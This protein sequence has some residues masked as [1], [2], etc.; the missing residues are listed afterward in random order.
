MSA[1]ISI[2][3]THRIDA[4]TS[5]LIERLIGAL[6][7]TLVG[8]ETAVTNNTSGPSAAASAQ[9][10]DERTETPARERGKPATG[11]KRR[12]KEEVAEDAAAGA[13]TLAATD[14]AEAAERKDGR[15]AT[16]SGGDPPDEGFDR[17]S[18]DKIREGIRA[19]NKA[20]GPVETKA[21]FDGLTGGSIS[22]IKDNAEY[23]V[24]A[25]RLA[26][27]LAAK[28]AESSAAAPASTGG[29]FD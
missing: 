1:S 6:D 2:E 7:A 15:E 11:K 5:N 24:L 3:I 4:P 12:T 21:L 25:E 17:K 23:P 10:D 27:A 29:T 18:V 16:P 20:H 9:A 28:E 26:A 8:A 14:A 19:F 13:A 22:T